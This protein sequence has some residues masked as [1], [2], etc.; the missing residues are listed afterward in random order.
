MRFF[1]FAKNEIHVFCACKNEI[2]VFWSFSSLQKMKF[3]FFE[4]FLSLQKKNEIHVFWGFLSLQNSKKVANQ[5]IPLKKFYFR[6]GVTKYFLKMYSMT[7]SLFHCH[8][9]SVF[10]L[11]DFSKKSTFISTCQGTSVC[12]EW[13][14]ILQVPWLKSCGGTFWTECLYSGSRHKRCPINPAG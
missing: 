14:R 1:K 8:F 6:F 4:I 5:F 9:S 10:V 7:W 2:H 13:E 12:Q 3:M 11:L